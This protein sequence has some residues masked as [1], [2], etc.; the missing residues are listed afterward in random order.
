[1][2]RIEAGFLGSIV[3]QGTA[4]EWHQAGPGLEELSRELTQEVLPAGADDASPNGITV[5]TR[6]AL[7]ILAIMEEESLAHALVDLVE[8]SQFA[9]WPAAGGSSPR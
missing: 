2:M 4:E 9:P 1:M 5:T 7:T 8:G 3:L 6:Q